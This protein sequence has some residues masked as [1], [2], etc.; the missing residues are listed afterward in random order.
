MILAALA[1]CESAGPRRSARGEA[2]GD[3]AA[4]AVIP[5]MEARGTFF[6]GRIEAEVLLARVGAHWK[7]QDDTAPATGRREAGG[8]GFS[9]RVGGFGGG[10]GGHR[11]GGGRGGG[12]EGGGESD[13][14]SRTP[15]H[16]SNLPAAALRLRLT[17]HG[18][19]PVAV[20]VVDFDSSL[21]DFVVEPEKIAL[22][23]DTPTEAEP[24]ISR[25]GIG[26]EDIPLTVRLR[27]GGRGEQQV[28]TLREVSQ[29][30]PGSPA[31][32]APPAGPDRPD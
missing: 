32:T 21:G 2:P 31:P 25:L 18:D 24:M 6:D 23:P 19:A 16:A 22:P 5:R 1:A 12:G 15:I 9:G 30:A 7:R 27:L 14:P 20:E 17:N 13:A 8:G 26:T 4:A 11:G 3:G 10:H 29:P 28:L